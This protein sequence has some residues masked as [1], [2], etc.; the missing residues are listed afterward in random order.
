M[1]IYIY[2]NYPTVA[3]KTI[4]DPKNRNPGKYIGR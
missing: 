1:Y 3:S 2:I 4:I